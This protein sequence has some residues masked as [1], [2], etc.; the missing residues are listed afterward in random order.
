M[1]KQQQRKLAYAERNKQQDKDSISAEIYRRVLSQPWYL[2]AQTI[3]WYLH[4]RS[5]VRTLPVVLEQLKGAQRI[6]I[7]YCT[8]DEYGERCLGLWRLE[9]IEELVP[10]M[11]DILEPPRERWHQTDKQIKPEELD[12]VIVPGVA[13]DRQGARL[14]NGA[15]YYDRLLQNV[16]ADTMLAGIC[17]QAQ[18]MSHIAMESHDVYMNIVITEQAIYKGRRGLC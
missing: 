3:L 14:G 12:V 5:E 11:W 2:E 7:P 16:R 15:G 13:F 10:G 8:Q 17:Y 1:D 4:C 9:A 18:I 6:V